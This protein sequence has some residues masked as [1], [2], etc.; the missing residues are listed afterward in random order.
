MDPEDVAET[1]DACFRII[2][3]IVLHHGGTVDKFIGDCAMALFG[4]PKALEHAPRQAVN[5]S[6]EIRSRLQ[7]FSAQHRLPSPIDVHVGVNTGLVVGGDIGG[8]VKRDYT[9][10]GPTVNLASRLQSAASDGQIYVG[11]STYRVTRR[12]FE[13]D[14]I[15]GLSV[16]GI[17]G[18]VTA[19]DLKSTETSLYGAK[20][21]TEGSTLVSTLVGRDGELQS[22]ERAFSRLRDGE[23][24]VVEIE[25]PNGMG[26]SRLYAEARALDA[27][28]G[29][30]VLEGR[31]L[32]IGQSLSFHP[33]VDLMKTWLDIG[34]DVSDADRLQNLGALVDDIGV[35][36]PA[37]VT[38]SIARSMGL[39]VADSLADAITGVEG[40]ALEKLIHKSY[41]ALLEKLAHREPLIVVIEDLH[42]ADRSS[43]ALFEA[44]LPLV[45]R[46][47]ILFLSLFRPGYEETSEP[48][49][50]RVRQTYGLRC[51]HIT[52]G[53]LGQRECDRLIDNL[54]G[55]SALPHETRRHI[56][57]KTDGN[58]F[59][60]EEVLRSLVERGGLIFK[61]GKLEVTELLPE[62]EIPGTIEEVI[63]SRVERL[64]DQCRHVL[65]MASVVGR[66]FFLAIL[67]HLVE[68]DVSLD[69]ALSTLVERQ[70]IRKAT[71]RRTGNIKRRA[72]HPETEYIFQ[73][74][75]VQD[76]VY[77]S[78]LKRTRRSLHARAAEA[79]EKRYAERVE[80]F[81]GMLAY[82]YSRAD[83]LDVAESY[84]EKAGE[85][86]ARSAASAEA[87]QYFREAYRIYLK[88]HGEDG[89]DQKKAVLEKNIGLALLN[90]GALSESVEHFNRALVFYGERVPTSQFAIVTKWVFDFT[91]VLVHLYSGSA[92]RGG[93]RARENDQD[94]FKI[95]TNRCRAQ[96]A[97]DPERSFYD[98]MAA[99]RHTT[100]LDTAQIDGAAGIYSA[101]GAF[102]AFAGL[103]FKVGRRFLDVS[104][105]VGREDSGPDRFQ[106]QA[107]GAVLRF[108]AGE[109]GH[110]QD[111]PDELLLQGLRV[112][113]LWDA[114]VY[115]GMVAERD[116]RQGNFDDARR[117]IEK[118]D[119]LQSEYGYDFASSN[120]A[121]MRAMLCIE[122]RELDDAT[123]AIN[124]YY[125]IRH[126]DTLHVLALSWRARIE[127]HASRL[128]D[129][130]ATLA[131]AEEIISRTGRQAPF[132]SGAYWTSRLMVN[133]ALYEQDPSRAN[134]KA[135]T[136]A[137]KRATRGAD[138]IMR[139]AVEANRL[140]AR[141]YWASGARKKAMAA[142][143]SA[144]SIA[145]QLEARPEQARTAAD[146]GNALA[147]A[148]GDQKFMDEGAD[149]WLARAAAELARLG[150]DWDL[151]ALP[152]RHSDVVLPNLS[153]RANGS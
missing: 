8:D 128:D 56:K 34:E 151:G 119:A 113:L 54:L 149:A 143:T 27:A 42:W 89:D 25:A 41:V 112:G 59:Y 144:L 36:R 67:D 63:T 85:E 3:Q 79:I 69:D 94:L 73:H 126:E 15:K 68:G 46:S 124:E 76:A 99:M 17:E 35:E 84:L 71:S 26:K 122:R 120:A 58:P 103:S 142:W 66:R 147:G 65:Q 132:Y 4:A 110:E 148:D 72:L 137:L 109:W 116:I 81:Y 106:L 82:H 108:H 97:T 87:L 107:M 19:Y 12:E 134:A 51:E 136:T 75:L 24:G 44:I 92:R 21:Q 146:I 5:A 105:E 135:V 40:E 43:L 45:E 95:M 28:D 57:E 23:G 93:G 60:V 152:A 14:E 11:E 32:S 18:P 123:L 13:Y 33:F 114:D 48:F 140:A 150:L 6:I 139:E 117:S 20:P 78:L 91:R 16:K 111:I 101:I 133:V 74:A 38:A 118:L 64:D 100:H 37:E 1:I 39:D 9:V 83:N 104:A 131:E 22:L 125:E 62:L 7:R 153:K 127:T 30:L 53:P 80:D 98:N 49:S 55:T 138:K 102:F 70:F 130:V 29:I 61:K 31:C 86:A 77:A 121:A 96:N 52:L 141:F 10:M 50:A 88:L 145:D 47:G 2:E 129:A 115:L 90:T